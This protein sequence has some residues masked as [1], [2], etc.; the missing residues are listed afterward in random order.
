MHTILHKLL[1]RS[2]G[3]TEPKRHLIAL[4]EPPITYCEGSVLLRCLFHLYL[5]ASGFKIQARKVASA[6]QALQCLLYPGERVG[7]L[8]H[9]SIQVAKVDAKMQATTLFLHQH[10]GITPCTLARSDSTRFQHF[11]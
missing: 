5:P 3:I 11:L 2:R 10:H 6:H 4:K 1:K 7:I 9:T 8:L